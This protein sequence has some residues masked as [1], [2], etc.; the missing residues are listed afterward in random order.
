MSIINKPVDLSET[1][2][3]VY[4][5]RNIRKKLGGYAN[6]ASTITLEKAFSVLYPNKKRLDKSHFE[7]HKPSGFSSVKVIPF[8]PRK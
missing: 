5:K 3:R 2:Y 7:T 1:R 4:L 6:D 8:D